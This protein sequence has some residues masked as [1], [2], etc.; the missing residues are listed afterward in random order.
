MREGEARM[1]LAELWRY[2]VKS[3]AGERLERVTLGLAG[4]EGDRTIHVQNGRGRV[5]TA[6]THPQ[7]LRHR[8]VATG[9]G[10]TIVDGLPWAHP[11]IAAAIEKDAGPGALLVPDESMDR[12]DVLPLL[13][14]TDGAIK[15]FGHDGRRLRPN[16]VIGG[17]SGLEERSW[18]GKFLRIGEAV[19]SL[20]DLRGRCV[21]T[22][23]D[24]DTL[25]QNRGVLREIVRRFEGTLALN[26]SVV[27]G[28]LIYEGQPVD[29]FDTSE[30]AMAAAHDK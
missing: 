5:V 26:A 4:V 8:A 29:L 30:Q 23:F 16:L 24:P 10:N 21:M 12:F 9:D 15:E 6:R 18:P 11:E 19:I 25:E 13:V 20:V 27:Q 7:L 17:V 28:G 1:Y 2:P 3:M 14:A 22:T